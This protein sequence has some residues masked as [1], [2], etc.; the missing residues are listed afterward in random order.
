MQ[1]ARVLQVALFPMALF[2]ML[3]EELGPL[4]EKHRQL[5]VTAAQ[6]LRLVT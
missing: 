6:I 4:P 2:P 1:F 3:Q 5:V